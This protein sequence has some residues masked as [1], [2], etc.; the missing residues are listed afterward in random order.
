MGAVRPDS[1]GLAD[2]SCSDYPN[3]YRNLYRLLDNEV[4]HVRYRAR[5]LR[6]LDL[7]LQSTNLPTALVASFIKKLARLSLGAPP[8][9]IV[10]TIPL[11]YNM[12]KR[13]TACMVLIHGN[14]AEETY[15]GEMSCEHATHSS[16]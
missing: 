14:A 8:A 3:F 7:F 12:L 4:M 1:A 9:A 13:H 6:M 16:S 15:Q 5:F 10:S 11:I 2:L